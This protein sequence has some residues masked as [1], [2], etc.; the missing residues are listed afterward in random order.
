M[1]TGDRTVAILHRLL[2]TLLQSSLCE[3]KRE[4]FGPYPNVLCH[5]CSTVTHQLI[6]TERQGAWGINEGS[7]CQ[8]LNQ[9]LDGS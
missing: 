8:I 4:A 2:S 9:D 3:G 7:V 6:F 1:A 5:S